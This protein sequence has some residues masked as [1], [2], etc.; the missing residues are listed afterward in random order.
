MRLNNWTAYANELTS[1]EAGNA[2]DDTRIDFPFEFWGFFC[3]SLFFA[4]RSG[5]FVSNQQHVASVGVV[6]LFP[7]KEPAQAPPP[8][9]P[10]ASNQRRANQSAVLYMDA[11][12][13]QPPPPEKGKATGATGGGEGGGGCYGYRLGGL[14]PWRRG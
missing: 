10:P 12:P 8:D 11:S 1:V 4:L 3:S 7:G 6:H 5:L 9:S 2:R 14:L 13:W